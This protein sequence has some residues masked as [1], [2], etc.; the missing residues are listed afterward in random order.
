[1]ND[2]LEYDL[3]E[4]LDEEKLDEYR[5][6][7]GFCESR[8]TGTEGIPAIIGLDD[9]TDTSRT[10][11]QTAPCDEKVK[12]KMAEDALIFT[13]LYSKLETRDMDYPCI[14]PAMSVMAELDYHTDEDG[15]ILTYR[16]MLEKGQ[17]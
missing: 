17:E 6:I 3:L 8:K 13:Y 15:N 1:M 10:V 2:I 12:M 4:D 9:L 7:I 16:E 5:K 14:A 11:Y